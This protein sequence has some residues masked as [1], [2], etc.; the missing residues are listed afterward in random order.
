MTHFLRGRSDLAR[1]V[2]EEVLAAPGAY[3]A[4]AG[5]LSG[6]VIAEIYLTWLLAAGGELERSAAHA[7]EAPERAHRA[8]HIS[9]L[10]RALDATCGVAWL[11]RD[12]AAL[13]ARARE[14]AGLVEAHGYPHFA[15]RARSYRGWIAVEAGRVA[16]GI[17]LMAGGIA[18]QRA[19]GTALLLPHL[20]AMLSDAHM[21]AGDP[22]AALAHIDEALRISVRTGE[23]WFD[24]EL[25][26][27]LGGLLLRLDPCG[28]ARA[29][30]E[31]R[32]ALEIARSQ[33][34]RLFELRA[35]CD[36]ARLRREQGRIADARDLL[37]PIYASFTE[38]FAFP[39][40]I[41]TRALLEELGATPADGAGRR[42]E[43]VRTLQG[44]DRL[45]GP[46]PGR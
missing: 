29:E 6:G 15:A 43:E 41:E 30:A 40:L 10:V 45:L 27:R 13:R 35:A 11:A 3:E 37:A 33:S 17:D 4:S 25:H 34:A 23:V 5:F 20:E 31:F 2:F 16:E 14:L 22:D 26:R 9:S 28:A 12:P 8:G 46:V 42:Q 7:G 1:P 44:R 19:V 24:A 36:L 32:R 21:L 18:A 39:D 38:G